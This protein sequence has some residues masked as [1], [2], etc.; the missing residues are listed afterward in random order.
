LV[1]FD[2]GNP[3]ILRCALRTGGFASPSYDGF[4]FVQRAQFTALPQTNQASNC[5]RRR[6]E[7]P[8]KK[9]HLP[10]VTREIFT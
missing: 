3:A 10:A 9:I 2:A 4:A 6:S 5:R 1:F 7:T 8:Q